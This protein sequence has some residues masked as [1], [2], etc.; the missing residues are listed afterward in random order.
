METK[1]ISKGINDVQN[2]RL[3]KFEL[4]YKDSKMKLKISAKYIGE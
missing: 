1:E 4:N 2:G 3:S